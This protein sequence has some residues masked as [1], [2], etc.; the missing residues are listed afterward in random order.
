MK[1]AIGGITPHAK[2]Y[3]MPYEVLIFEETTNKDYDED[4]QVK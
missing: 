2:I 1:C 3:Q 4:L